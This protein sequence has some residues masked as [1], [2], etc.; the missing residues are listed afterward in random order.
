MPTGRT[1]RMR[2]SKKEKGQWPGA[3][4]QNTLPGFQRPDSFLKRRYRSIKE[5]GRKDPGQ[6]KVRQKRTIRGV[7]STT[8]P[9]KEPIGSPE[10][11]GS[12]TG[13]KE[14]GRTPK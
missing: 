1:S 6:I 8:R 14:Q 3:S 11:N 4:R 9:W 7:H 10:I 12:K 2:R 5:A 13:R